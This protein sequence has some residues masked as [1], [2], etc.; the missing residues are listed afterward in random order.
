[1]KSF[2]SR[3]RLWLPLLV[4]LFAAI[5][6]VAVLF[7]RIGLGELA[8]ILAPLALI[9][10]IESGRYI[11]RQLAKGYRGPGDELNNKTES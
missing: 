9:V 2:A 11:V 10:V 8:V 7:R 3:R 6:C 4:L 1:M 5:G